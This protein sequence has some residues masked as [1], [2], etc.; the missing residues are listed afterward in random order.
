MQKLAITFGMAKCLLPG[1]PRQD[2]DKA[3]ALAVEIGAQ[4]GA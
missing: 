1:V 4:C 2:A 3:Y